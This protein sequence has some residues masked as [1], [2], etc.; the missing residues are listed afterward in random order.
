MKVGQAAAASIGQMHRGVW[1][2]GR[3]VAVK[4]QYR[5]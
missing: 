1:R 4:V 3:A 2:D 5:G